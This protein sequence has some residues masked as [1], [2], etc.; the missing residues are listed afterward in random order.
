MFVD[1]RNSLRLPDYMQNIEKFLRLP[2]IFTLIYVFGG[3]FAGLNYPYPEFLYSS[4][5][6][7]PLVRLFGILC[8]AFTATGQIE[9]ALVGTII[10]FFVI[11]ILRTPEERKKYPYGI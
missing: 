5:K 6:K 10:F 1:I 4:F 7:Y 2:L 11:N 9:Y 3:I 8:L